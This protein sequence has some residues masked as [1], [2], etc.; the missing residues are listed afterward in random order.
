[1]KP[2]DMSKILKGSE[3]LL[4]DA[5]RAEI[6][7]LE[8]IREKFEKQEIR[9]FW[10][11]AE[12]ERRDN[13]G[14]RAL[15]A[16]SQLGAQNIAGVGT[17]EQI[18]GGVGTGK[19]AITVYT[20]FKA[21]PDMVKDDCL[22]PATFDGVPVNV[23]ETGFVSIQ[24]EATPRAKFRPTKCGIS[25]GHFSIS[26]GTLGCLCATS[27][28]DELIL[29]NNHV[30]AASNSA[31]KGDDILQPGVAD[32]GNRDRDKLGELYDFKPIDFSGGD[33][34]VDAALARPTVSVDPVIGTGRIPEIGRVKGF[35]CNAGRG[36]A[37]Q[38]FGRTTGH[39]KGRI[40]AVNATFTINF[41]EAGNPVFTGLYVVKPSMPHPTF[42]QGG[43]SG[44]LIVDNSNR[45]IALLF[46]GSTAHTLAIPICTVMEILG[47]ERIL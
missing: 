28:E 12:S 39:T 27:K 24:Q 32:S 20:E 35:A 34:K 4:S 43:D 23:I 37:V 47:I 30:L 3:N 42:S 45:A 5:E 38:K 31:N 15:E 22:M 25:I 19:L 10:K 33:N 44:S 6:E 9:K 14:F 8:T 17:G 40:D 13:G 29:S 16:G 18:R 2:I 21:S 46:A 26:A 7:Q 11:E 41:R 36:T 1:V